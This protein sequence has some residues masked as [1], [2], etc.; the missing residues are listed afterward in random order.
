MTAQSKKLITQDIPNW[1]YRAALMGMMSLLLIWFN[2]FRSEYKELKIDHQ[3]L[4]SDFHA[5]QE[6]EIGQVNLLTSN[7]KILEHNQNILFG[8]KNQTE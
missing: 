4:K 1:L 3:Q 5:H 7:I 2:D 8:W 6:K